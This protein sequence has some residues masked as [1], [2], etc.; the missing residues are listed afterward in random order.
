MNLRPTAL[1]IVL[2]LLCASPHV[3]AAEG[4]LELYVDPVTGQIFARPGPGLQALG[5]FRPVTE[6]E[7]AEEESG[8][9]AAAPA[10]AP[11]E[12]ADWTDSFRIRGYLQTR[13]TSML[14]GDKGINLWPD[15]SVGDADSLGNA[16]KNFLIR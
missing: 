7:A 16:D 9:A 2:A 14:G 1:Q 3:H 11:V 12:T 4:D 15:R 6:A 8:A 10:P 13:Y 5:T